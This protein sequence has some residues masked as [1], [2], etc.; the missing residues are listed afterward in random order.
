MAFI[1]LLAALGLVAI[2]QFTKFLAIKYIEPMPTISLI[3]FGDKEVLNFTY[4]ENTGAAFSILEG[5]RI[6]LIIITSIIILGFIVFLFTKYA[7]DKR[8]VWIIA[9]LIGGGTG[10]LIDRIFHGYVVD[11][12]DLRI[13][14]FA[15]FNFADACTVVACILLFVYVMLTGKKEENKAKVENDETT[16][17]VDAGVIEDLTDNTNK[18][19]ENAN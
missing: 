17:V 18:I 2:D 6:P 8:L 11:F 16:S 19:I 1:A 5:F 7:K 12:I 3:K 13:I 10:N 9:L 15:V 14:N 4:Y